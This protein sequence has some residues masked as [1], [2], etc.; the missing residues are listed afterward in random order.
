MGENEFRPPGQPNQNNGEEFNPPGTPLSESERKVESLIDRTKELMREI[1]RI[2]SLTALSHIKEDFESVLE[3]GSSDFNLDS[4]LENNWYFD[5]NI[6]L[7]KS[8]LNDIAEKILDYVEEREDELKNNLDYGDYCR[9]KDDNYDDRTFAFLGEEKPDDTKVYKLRDKKT[10]ETKLIPVSA[11]PD[12]EYVSEQEYEEKWYEEN[13]DHEP[14]S[15]KIEENDTSGDMK[16]GETIVG[17]PEE[18]ET[19]TEEEA[20][21]VVSEEVENEKESLLSKLG[22]KAADV[23][24]SAK[25][26]VNDAFSYFS[27]NDKQE[28]ISEDIVSGETI[29]GNEEEFNEKEPLDANEAQDAV[30]E[31]I[32]QEK[33]KTG[34]LQNLGN[35]IKKYK[36]GI[37]ATM[38]AAVFSFGINQHDAS[39]YDNSRD[40][41]ETEKISPDS[42]EDEVV[43]TSDS[44]EKGR[45]SISDGNEE[46]RDSNFDKTGEAEPD[47]GTNTM[48]FGKS[49]SNKESKESL[50]GTYSFKGTVTKGSSPAKILESI[51]GFGDDIKDESELKN[52]DIEGIDID[53]ESDDLN[54]LKK[55]LAKSDISAVDNTEELLEFAEADDQKFYPGSIVKISFSVDEDGEMYKLN[56]E[57]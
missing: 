35:K 6:D 53:L 25:Q 22:S 23:I 44:Q 31:E 30:E 48:I 32:E 7:T 42:S 36:S 10:G 33:N 24:S 47:D 26:K 15:E 43:D 27:D 56:L 16:S 50:A 54:N 21:D 46:N 45:E 8:D 37:A 14:I 18:W 4:W 57:N 17:D 19:Q 20:R 9:I 49:E 40:R 52:L 51:W 11:T 1:D 3:S 5:S 41:A 34:F 12:F 29:V 39:K 2:E 38:T 55:V 28:D 13:R